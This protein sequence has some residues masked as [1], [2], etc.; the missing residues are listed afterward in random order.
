MSRPQPPSL[1]RGDVCYLMPERLDGTIACNL[2][3]GMLDL[4]G[5]GLQVARGR[6]DEQSS[7]MSH[8][9]CGHSESER[10]QDAYRLSRSR[11]PEGEAGKI[12]WL[13]R[14]CIDSSNG[15]CSKPTESKGR[16]WR[17]MTPAGSAMTPT[18]FLAPWRT[19]P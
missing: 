10:S 18:G 4:I 14:S 11:A 3:T 19:C 12:P 1:R 8:A 15:S 5:A 2:E 6:I 9:E 17:G 13:M 7:A 16:V